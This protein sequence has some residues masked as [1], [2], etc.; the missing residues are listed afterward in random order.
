LVASPI[1]N[2]SNTPLHQCRIDFQRQLTQF[3]HAIV[4]QRRS[5]KVPCLQ[6]SLYLCDMLL[7]TGIDPKLFV[8][9][10]D[11][12][13]STNSTSRDEQLDAIDSD[14]VEDILYYMLDAYMY[15]GIPVAFDEIDYDRVRHIYL[16]RL[17]Q[18]SSI[19]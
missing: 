10:Q 7:Y 2:T 15:H 18:C 16:A 6:V 17:F 5:A 11:T 4:A 9:L 19:I 1:P 3:F 13:T 8:D 14:D 12:N